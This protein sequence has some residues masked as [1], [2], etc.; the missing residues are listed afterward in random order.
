MGS[1]RA[2][3]AL[4]MVVGLVV[5]TGM[6]GLGIWQWHV[7]H[8][9]G[10]RAAAARAAEPP[11][12]LFDIARPSEPIDQGYGRSVTFFG[13]YQPDSQLLVPIA[14][15]HQY[16][17]LTA[18]VAPDGAAVPV[19]RG[20]VTGPDAP[21]PPSGKVDQVGVLSASEAAAPV[22]SLPTGQIG[23]VQ[24]GVLA[25]RWSWPLIG[26]YVTLSADAARQQGLTPATAP[27]PQA[28][29]SLRN[30]TYGIQWWVFAAFAVGMAAKMARDLGQRR[31]EEQ[32]R[33]VLPDAGDGPDA[34]DPHADDPHADDPHAD[35]PHADD[36]HADDLAGAGPTRDGGTLRS[37]R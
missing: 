32:D 24:L 26:G 9:S 31:I 37:A 28:D 5:A 25:Q 3:Q 30:A 29:G 7:F 22:Q 6:V 27:L 10:A 14:G 8:N 21:A 35:D 15:T 34:H 2:A 4:I 16:R 12:A 20:I 11:L 36:P 23:S 18:L 19:I 17:V 33:G 1:S 13:R